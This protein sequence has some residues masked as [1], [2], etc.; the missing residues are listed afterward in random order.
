[1]QVGILGGGESGVGAALLAQHVGDNPFVSDYG[2]LNPVFR[3]N[4]IE[5]NVRFEEGGHTFDVLV[6]SDVI[7]KSPG[8]ADTTPII[9]RLKK[10]GLSVISE[11]EYGFQYSK[12]KI[13]AI[14]G[15]NGKTTTTHLIYHLLMSKGVHAV[16]GGNL[17]TS[18][19]R[20]LLDPAYEVYVLEVS[21][22][23]LDGIVSFNPDIAVITNITPD[24]LD[25]YEYDFDKYADSKLR[26]SLNQT[27][28]ESFVYLSKQQKVLERL[29]S[30][31]ASCL[32]ITEDSLPPFVHNIENPHL[33][34][35][36]NQ[37]NISLA[38]KAVR[39]LIEIS[40][41]EVIN[42]LSTFVNDPHRLETIGITNQVL[43]INDSKAT[44]VDATFFALSTMSRSVIWI[45]G[46]VD[47]GNDYSRLK[48]IVKDKVKSILCLGDGW[49]N[50]ENAFSDLSI[51][52]ER[53]DNL[54][55]LMNRADDLAQAGDA[56]LLSP[57]CAS[58]DLFRNYEDR[59]EQFR[60]AVW[61]LL[62]KR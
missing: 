55:E 13:V 9:K 4:L 42:A 32:A 37:L 50:V 44:N 22:F 8:I 51:N 12:G 48:S 56:V 10:A 23:Q 35:F 14:T 47:K 7:I 26:I 3:Q 34:G 62:R 24:H 18:F 52:M 49:E 11:I 2:Q 1:V 5:N 38:V 17:G 15:S 58:F 20:L 25:R 19:A 36:H 21:S 40:D 27:P 41:D 54:E 53:F 46:G 60:S 39:N 28:Q 6:A 57:A 33:A 16:E 31:N 61:D 29:S 45:V 43:W 30:V 59:G